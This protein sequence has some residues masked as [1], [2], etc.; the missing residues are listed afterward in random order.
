MRKEVD[1][2]L[3]SKNGGASQLARLGVLIATQSIEEQIA[4]AA[5][6]RPAGEEKKE[7]A[8]EKEDKQEGQGDQEEQDEKEEIE[9]RTDENPEEEEQ[10]DGE[11]VPMKRD[12]P[13]HR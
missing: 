10:G 4:A 11:N 5:K 13:S 9:D 1:F 7:N 2:R 6:E 3:E 12:E 8:E